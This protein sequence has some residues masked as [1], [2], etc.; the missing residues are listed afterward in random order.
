MQKKKSIFL[1]VTTRG[2]PLIESVVIYIL[3]TNRNCLHCLIISCFKFE[4][5]K[6]GL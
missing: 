2:N 5:L 1:K 4:S 6:R 3:V